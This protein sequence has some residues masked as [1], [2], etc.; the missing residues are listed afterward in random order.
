MEGVIL[1]AFLAGLGFEFGVNALWDYSHTLYDDMMWSEP[2][3]VTETADWNM[4]PLLNSQ[5]R[6]VPLEALEPGSILADDQHAM[7]GSTATFR[8]TAGKPR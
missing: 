2:P 3:V 6:I 8:L 4:D 1:T 7:D 5:W